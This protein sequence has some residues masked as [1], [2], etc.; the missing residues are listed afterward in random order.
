MALAPTAATSSDPQ[1]LTDEGHAVNAPGLQYFVMALFF[2]FGGITSLNDVIL[3]KGNVSKRH[4][5]VVR[6]DGR[7]FVVDLKSTNGTYLNGRRITTPSVIRPGDKIY[8]GDFIVEVDMGEGASAEDMDNGAAG[9]PGPG[10]EV[11]LARQT[12]SSDAGS[13][14]EPLPI[15]REPSESAPPPPPVTPARAPSGPMGAVTTEAGAS[16]EPAR[17]PSV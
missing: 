13:V 10:A 4:S 9:M 1:P 17:A 3:P 12:A 11:P 5:R 8:V 2:I 7:F 15:D 6:Q 14:I 16:A